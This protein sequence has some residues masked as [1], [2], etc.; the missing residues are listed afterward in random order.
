MYISFKY[1]FIFL[2]IPKTAGSTMKFILFN[3]IKSLQDIIIGCG[4][5][6]LSERMQMFFNFHF[7]IAKHSSIEKLHEKNLL[8]YFKDFRIFTLFRDPISRLESCYSFCKQNENFYTVFKQF[9]NIN[10]FVQSE[11]FFFIEWD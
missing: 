7:G 4:G 10:D 1:K 5:I 11:H 9:N 3:E 6:E 2:H 8:N